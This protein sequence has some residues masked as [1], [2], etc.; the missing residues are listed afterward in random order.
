MRCMTQL[1]GVMGRNRRF[2]EEGGYVGAVVVPRLR[3]AV[4]TCLDPRVDPAWVLGLR[5]SEAIVI[6]NVGGRITDEVVRE[7]AYLGV[8]SDTLRPG[9]GGPLFEVAVMHHTQ[10][11]AGGLADAG[12]RERYAALIGVE[13][14]DV[15]RAGAVVDPVE[16]VR[17]DVARLRGAP[18]LQGRHPVSGHVYDVTTGLVRTV[19]DFGLAVPS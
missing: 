2:A 19:D 12:V 4:V 16:T 1:A 13:D 5:L 18:E 17:T 6:R 10:C 7:L 9:E 15:L 3:V 14:P 8:L 11:G